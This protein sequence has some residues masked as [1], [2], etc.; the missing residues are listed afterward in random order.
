MCWP[1]WPSRSGNRKAPTA[2]D[3]PMKLLLIAYHFP[4]DGEIGA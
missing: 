3:R 4:P 1:R 2:E